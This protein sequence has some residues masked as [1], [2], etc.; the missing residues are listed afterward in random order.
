VPILLPQSVYPV[1]N[2]NFLLAQSG[3]ELYGYAPLGGVSGL[4]YRLYG[5][6]ITFELP[7]PTPG[8][9]TVVTTLDTPYLIGGR[10]LWESPLEGLR[11]GG[12]VQYLELKSKLLLGATPVAVDV[13]ALLWIGS[14][15]YS[16]AGLHLASEYSR[17]HVDTESSDETLYPSTS[18]TSER[19][20]VMGS[21]RVAPWLEPGVYYSLVY[22][23]VEVRKGRAASQ[24]DIAATLRFDV[25]SNWLVKLEGHYMIGTAALSPSLNRGV[26]TSELEDHWGLILT[27]ITGYF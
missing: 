20:Y 3:G 13:P 25:G 27:K 18:T 24:H 11:V 21:Y 16:A 7:P 19:A 14:V 2:R 23:N 9:P 4:E 6:T 17:W 8:S 10:L 15:E 5:G 22:P 1:G 12:S 26:P